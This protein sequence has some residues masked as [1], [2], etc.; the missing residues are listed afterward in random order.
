MLRRNL[1]W[2]ATLGKPLDARRRAIIIAAMARIGRLAL[3]LLAAL[4]SFIAVDLFADELAGAVAAA[5]VGPGLWLAAGSRHPLLRGALLGAGW[6][7]LIGFVGGFF[8]PMLL[9]PDANQGPLLG[10]F[11]TGPGGT[12]LGAL[13]GLA[14]A[15]GKPG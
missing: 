3:A 15:A 6:G 4:A 9:A 1:A 11:I 2:P 5:L 7:G 14:I 12:L 13:I 8:G 10:L